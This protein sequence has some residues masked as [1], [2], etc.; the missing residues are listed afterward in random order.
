[1]RFGNIEL[2]TRTFGFD[3]LPTYSQYRNVN[4]DGERVADEHC[5]H[6]LMFRFSIYANISGWADRELD[7][8]KAA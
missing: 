8:K 6:W 7:N 2:G 1:M 4:L 3:W 5:F